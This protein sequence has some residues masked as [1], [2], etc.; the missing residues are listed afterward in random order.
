MKP[1]QVNKLYSKLQPIEQ[2][3]LVL[4]AAAKLDWDT[5]DAIIEKVERLTYRTY[6]DDY[7]RRILGLQLLAANYGIEYWKIRALM[8]LSNNY[9]R[10]GYIVAEVPAIKF[11]AKAVA[12]ESA[13]VE[14][15]TQFKVDVSAIRDIAGCFGNEALPKQ[16]PPVDE[17]LVRQYT[18]LLTG[19]IPS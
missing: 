15:C 2:A 5:V 6:H 14:I 17:S 1:E 11:L 7:S 3:T 9:A 8:L 19:L 16:L 10:A 13:I 18:H 12:L 4:E